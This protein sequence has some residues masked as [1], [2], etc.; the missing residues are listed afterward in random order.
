[1]QIGGLSQWVSCQKNGKIRKEKKPIKRNA[2][3][4]NG[5]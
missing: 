2:L 4:N 1:M 5:L 3:N